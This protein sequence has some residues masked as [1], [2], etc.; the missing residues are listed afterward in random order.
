MSIAIISLLTDVSLF[1]LFGLVLALLLVCWALWFRAAYDY[2]RP[3]LAWKVEGPLALS[4]Q[5]LLDS[6][7]WT[8]PLPV[9][10]LY[11]TVACNLISQ[12]C[13]PVLS[14]HASNPYRYYRLQARPSHQTERPSH[15][16]I[17]CSGCRGVWCEGCVPFLE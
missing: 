2:V 5:V 12:G 3:V 1:A 11:L 13:M 16:L 6:G 10:G 17:I 9:N 7:A 14:H 15:G 8:E 4:I